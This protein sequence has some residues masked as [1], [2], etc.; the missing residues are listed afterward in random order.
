MNGC[1]IAKNAFV[2]GPSAVQEVEIAMEIGDLS[3]LF[4]SVLRIEHRALGTVP[5]S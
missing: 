2:R 1:C 5:S 3:T 4:V